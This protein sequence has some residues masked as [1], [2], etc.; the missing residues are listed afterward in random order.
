MQGQGKGEGGLQC[1]M[2]QLNDASNTALQ[3]SGQHAAPVAVVDDGGCAVQSSP[4]VNVE[5]V[6]PVAVV[7]DGGCAAQSSPWVN[8]ETESGVHTMAGECCIAPMQ[9]G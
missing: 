6:T 5:T 2:V 3:S 4:W 7:D 9:R 1:D 8:V